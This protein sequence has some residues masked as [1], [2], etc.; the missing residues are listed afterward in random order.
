[1]PAE[2]ARGPLSRLQ[3][4]WLM[5]EATRRQPLALL[6][7]SAARRGFAPALEELAGE[8]QAA[9]IDAAGLRRRID[10]A[11]GGAYELELAALFAAYESL[12]DELGRT[13]AHQAAATAT[14]ALRTDPAAWH[15]RPV[16]F[17]GF[18]DLVR[19][20][21]ELLDALA[22]ATEVTFAILYEDRIALR[23]RA[24]LPAILRDELGGAAEDPRPARA[25]ARPETLFELER[26]LFEPE[27]ARLEPDGSLHFLEAHGTAGEAELIG[28]KAAGL[29]AGGVDPGRIAVAVRSPSAQ[30]APLAAVLGRLGVPA[31]AEAPVAITET[32]TGGLI[33]QLLAIAAGEEAP[34]QALVSL[35]RAPARGRPETVDWF[36]RELRRNRIETAAEALEIWTAKGRDVWELSDLREA[37]GEG[38]GAVASTLGR[39]ARTI[40]ERPGLR[41]APLPRGADSVELRAAAE[42]E[43]GLLEACELGAHAPAVDELGELLSH[44]QVPLWRGSTEGRVRILSPYRLRASE[45]DHLFIAGLN[46]GVFPGRGTDEPLLSREGRRRLG[47]PERR[48]RIDEERFLFHSCVARPSRSLT[49]SWIGSDDSGAPAARSPFIDDVRALLDPEPAA[50]G[51]DELERLLTT[52]R[53]PGAIVPPP[54][55]ATS[56][57]D[58]ARAV[59]PLGDGAAEALA[60]L[61]L[62]ETIRKQTLAIV[63]GAVAAREAAARPGPLSHPPVLEALATRDLFGSTTLEEYGAC[64]YVWFTRHELGPQSIE[65]TPEPLADGGL[66]H[67]ALEDLYRARP[68]GES[69]P[70][71]DSVDG[72]IEAGREQLE[73]AALARGWDPQAP[74]TRISVAKLEAL[75]ARFLR[76]DAQWC[77]PLET[78]VTLLEASFGEGP[79]DQFPAAEFDG[80]RLHGKIDRID[81]SGE[82]RALI[83]DYKSSRVVSARKKL[84]DEGKLQ[85][86]LYMRAVETFPDRG[87]SVIGGVYHPL[88]G[89]KEDR[90]RGVLDKDERDAL[91][92]SDKDAYVS[93]DFAERAEIEELL[94]QAER[95]ANDIV[96]RIRA[97]RIARNPRGGKCPP[98]C[99]YA[100][101]CRIERGDPEPIEDEDEDFS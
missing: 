25:G 46:D 78:D 3:R 68:G 89:T 27:A 18:D 45:V 66:L 81:V 77:S 72:W 17:Y 43:A 62:P 34:P 39:I 91:I 35:L 60:A 31:A 90:P 28:R 57:P 23:A 12:R 26:R 38:P 30:A 56:V 14:A 13:D 16:F 36:E 10:N 52:R 47:L 71:P 8:L 73:A 59:A 98:Y 54:I 22:T 7:R 83:R 64:S 94:E 86:P 51:G 55:E 24:E 49:L 2:E 85:I 15:G 75:I 42:I 92:A 20:Q 33:M 40:A 95:A 100:A 9:G 58:L 44:V 37:V 70:T 88:G 6:R 53:D 1:M 21:I 50:E 87:L 61:E 63:A 19:E 65:P 96:A 67:S 79:D 74:T 84:I 80:W 82:G 76:R 4:I 32:A 99:T 29:I 48:E 97:G 11:G 69:N 93:T 5:R 41:Q 101:I